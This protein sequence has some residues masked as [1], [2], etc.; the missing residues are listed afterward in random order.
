MTGLLLTSLAE[1]AEN[2]MLVTTHVASPPV[3]G[4]EECGSEGCDARAVLNRQ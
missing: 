2:V 1:A 3:N 4:G